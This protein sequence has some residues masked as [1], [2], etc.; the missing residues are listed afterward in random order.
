MKSL[1]AAAAPVEISPQG[2]RARRKH[3]KPLRGGLA[4][5]FEW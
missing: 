3:K 4:S 1:E 2:D 5:H